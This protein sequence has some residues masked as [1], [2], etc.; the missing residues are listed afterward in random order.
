MTGFKLVLHGAYEQPDYIKN[1]PRKYD[2][3]MLDTPKKDPSKAVSQSEMVKSN[4]PT[5]KKDLSSAEV[6]QKL[7]Q[8]MNAYQQ[9][10]RKNYQYQD[11][12]E[13]YYDNDNEEND[14]AYSEELSLNALLNK[15]LN[16]HY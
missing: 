13:Y 1:G 12:N 11:S 10:F 5:A 14:Q 15:L 3:P 16:K 6:D 2:E 7:A 4:V 8:K 9:I